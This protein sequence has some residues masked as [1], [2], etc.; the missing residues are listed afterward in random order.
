MGKVFEVFDVSATQ[1]AKFATSS[2]FATREG[3]FGQGDARDFSTGTI[4]ILAKMS[5][6]DGF[7]FREASENVLNLQICGCR[8]RI[9]RF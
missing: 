9:M 8:L 7:D 6:E 5:A 1:V 2:S 4:I 3:K